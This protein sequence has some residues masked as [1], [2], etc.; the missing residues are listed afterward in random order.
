MKHGLLCEFRAGVESIDEYKERFELYC[1]ANAVPIG[2]E[3]VARRKAIFLTSVGAST[4]SLLR[5]SVRL[6]QPQDLE[7]DDIIQQLRNHYEPKKIVI[8]ERFRYYKR[9]Q[10]EGETVAVFLS[11][12]RRLARH[13]EFGDKSVALRDQFVCGL[14]VEAL[15]QKVLAETDLTLEKAVRIAQAFESA[16]QETARRHAQTRINNRPRDGIYHAK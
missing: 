8:A 15:Q 7:L 11:E 1:L 14:R 6:R 10:K 4:Y 16:R 9:Q 3:H 2:D 13:C 12:L 5:T